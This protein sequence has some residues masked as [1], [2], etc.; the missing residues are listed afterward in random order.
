M[1]GYVTRQTKV[2]EVTRWSE[3]YS[4]DIGTVWSAENF[5]GFYKTKL[6]GKTKYFKGEMAE[7]DIERMFHDAGDW[8]C[9]I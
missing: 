8:N 6:N 2:A 3:D 5:F 1:T 9:R 4:S 7:M